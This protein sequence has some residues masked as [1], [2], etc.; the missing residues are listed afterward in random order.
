[1]RRT[2]RRGRGRTSTGT[3]IFNPVLSKH[4]IQIR[5][6]IAKEEKIN[7]RLYTKSQNIIDRAKKWGVL[8]KRIILNPFAAPMKSNLFTKEKAIKLAKNH[9]EYWKTKTK[10]VHVGKNYD[11]KDKYLVFE[12]V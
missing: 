3:T 4:Q 7:E 9:S 11:N 6:D 10:I 8:S 1:M 2:S 5:S 12:W